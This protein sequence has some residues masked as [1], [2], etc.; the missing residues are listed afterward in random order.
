MSMNDYILTLSCP[1]RTGIVHSVSGWLLEQNGN[2]LEA[3][4]FGDAATNR[5]FLR[6]Q[7]SLPE[8]QDVNALQTSFAPIAGKFSMDANIYDAQRKARLLIL[9]SRQGHCLNDLLFRAHSGQLPVEIAAVASNHTDH[10]GLASSY[11]IPFH[12][13]PV[14]PETRPEQEQQII[15]LARDLKIDLV[16]LARYMQ[17]LSTNLC[18][19]LSGRAINIH[20]S[21][22][23]SFKGARPYHQAHARGVKII[24]ATAH[25][26][27]ADLDEGPIIEQ[28]VEHV[29]HSVSPAEL[30]QIGSDVESLVLARAVRAHVEHRILL[31]DQRTVVFR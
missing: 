31:N 3:Q 2:I 28:D 9:V 6:I 1:D 23:P 7:F 20:H 8:K 11:G 4:Q 19:S 16:V 14:T 21:F 12:H 18:Q 24:G 15:D 17:I 10:A 22:L 25:Y 26:V 27:T 29:T 5:F 30:T 13:L